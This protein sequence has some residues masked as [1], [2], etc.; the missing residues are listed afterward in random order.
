M[1]STGLHL[2]ACI[3]SSIPP[4]THPSLPLLLP[5]YLL[6]TSLPNVCQRLLSR[7]PPLNSLPRGGQGLLPS[8]DLLQDPRSSMTPHQ[9]PPS[10]SRCHPACLVSHFLI[11]PHAPSAPSRHRVHAQLLQATN[12]P[13][14]SMLWGLCLCGSIILEHFL[15]SVFSHIPSPVGLL[16]LTYTDVSVI[17]PVALSS[18]RHVPRP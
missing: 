6:S 11:P 5:V 9:P 16:M 3:R 7:L 17:S 1:R 4:L 8:P 12:E 10:W 15:P 13:P 18:G 14:R 2:T